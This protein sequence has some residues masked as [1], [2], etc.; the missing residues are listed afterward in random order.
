MTTAEKALEIY[1]VDNQI[2]KLAEECGE[3]LSAVSKRRSGR[4]DVDAVAEEI[5]D[6]LIMLDQMQ[7]AFECEE[8]VSKYIRY[9][10][11]RLE[12]RLANCP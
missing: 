2:I 8:V 3:L 1:G 6:V 10:L 7:T 5:A 12:N 9:K 11:D 4:C